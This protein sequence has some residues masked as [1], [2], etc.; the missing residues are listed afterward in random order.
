MSRYRRSKAAGSTFFFT[1]V[2]YRRQAILCDE[3][4]RV[5]LRDSVN[6]VRK[7]RP[8]TIDAWVLLPD[9]LHCVWTLPEGDSD[10]STRWRMIKHA[11]STTCRDA[12]RRPEWLSRSKHSHREST[13]WQRRFW[14]HQIRDDKDFAR[15]LDYIT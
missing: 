6:A 3:L 2:S 13:F 9:H 15:H 10:F 11:V 12:Y 7:K 1:V 5:A 14:E 8:F 4:I